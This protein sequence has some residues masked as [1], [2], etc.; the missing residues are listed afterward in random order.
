[1]SISKYWLL[2][3]VCGVRSWGPEGHRIVADLAE[4][5]L[6]PEAKR[7]VSKILSGSS[8]ASV[9][10][11]ADEID[12]KPEFAWTKCMHYIDASSGTCFVDINK[13]CQN[14]CCVVKAIANYTERMVGEDEITDSL[15]FLIHFMGD[16]H[17]PLHAGH[18]E[19]KGGN[20]IEIF[21]DFS[22][23][24]Q[25]R[26][27]LHEVWDG[28][29]IRHYLETHKETWEQYSSKIFEKISNRT[30]FDNV[31]ELDK[32]K[33]CPLLAAQESA[34]DACEFAYIDEN[35][36]QISSGTHLSEHYYSARID[37]AEQRLALAGI[38]L[39][40]TLNGIFS[41]LIRELE[42]SRIVVQEG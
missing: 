18:R 42:D 26:E 31:C 20:M 36:A 5:L 30:Y 4:R 41:N 38:R 29:L 19:D 40:N 6:V 16:V 15:K 37:I 23:V 3:F 14:N 9:A 35:G 21:P 22:P 27:N 11:W 8:M 10:T 25:R 28:V 24:H 1:M 39:G 34:S 13:D 32:M 33:K 17:Q 12:H 2:L 7:A